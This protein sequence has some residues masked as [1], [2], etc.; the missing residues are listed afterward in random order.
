VSTLIGIDLGTSGVK[1]LAIDNHGKILASVSEEYPLI[2]PRDGWTEQKAEEWWQ[3]V[4]SGIQK[5]LNTPEVNKNS[6]QALALSGQMHGSVFLDKNNQVI[7]NPI[8]W[9]DTRTLEQCQKITQIVG[10]KNLIAMVGNP[11]LEG[12]TLPKLL[13]LRDNEPDNYSQLQT[14]MLPKDYIV[15]RLTGRLCTEVSDAAGSLLLDVKQRKWSSELCHKLDIDSSILPEI[16]ES[17]DLAGTLT[18]LAANETGLSKSVKVI[19]GGADNA[20]GAVGNGIVSEGI[21][22]ASI[23]SSGVVLGSTDT[24]QYDPY[25]RIHSFNHAVPQKWYL[26]GVTLSAGLSMRWL[27][28]DL[29]NQDYDI[30]NKKAARIPAGS[31]GVLFLPYLYGERTPHRD[32]KAR[33]AFI[34]LSGIHNQAHL[35][36]AIFEGVAFALK[37]SFELIKAL[38]VQPRE[39]RMTGGG[40]KS[41]LWRQIL[42][43]IFNNEVCTMQADEGPAF[44]AAIIAGV[45]AGIYKSI[46]DATNQMVA[47]DESVHPDPFRAEKYQEIYP[48]FK[49]SYQ[50]LKNDYHQLF[51]INN[52]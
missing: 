28:N 51:E 48:V 18:D 38:G 36:R 34:G 39:V 15:Y 33:G 42:A 52:R 8:L 23:G 27:K 26:M 3:A 47:L 21:I 24:M 16:L 41:M 19:A 29:L 40:A 22:L 11:A 10:E 31:E 14:M 13:W 44:G 30:I 5:I 49:S 7:R 2:Q 35:I 6:I 17:V 45:G 4:I 25:G 37:D 20:C 12:F 50:S 1:I 46:E 32:P 43:D 9:N